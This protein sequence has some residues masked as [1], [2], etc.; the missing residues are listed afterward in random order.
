MRICKTFEWA[1]G[2]K[3]KHLMYPSKC[4]N[5]HGHN[6]IV[7]IEVEGPVQENGMV[8]D[9]SILK[10]YVEQV[11]FDHLY[12]NRDIPAFKRKNPTAENIVLYLKKE[13]DKEFE[14]KTIKIRRIRVWETSESYAEEVWEKG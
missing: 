2:H 10:A 8:I 5:Q 6:A 7:E 11:S 4:S 12:L 13:L 9:F 14:G 3:L 1:Y